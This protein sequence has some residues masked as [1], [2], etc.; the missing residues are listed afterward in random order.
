MIT[1]LQRLSASENIKREVTYKTIPANP[2]KYG[3]IQQSFAVDLHSYIPSELSIHVSVPNNPQDNPQAKM[4]TNND[5]H[6]KIFLY[7]GDEELL[8]EL[9]ELY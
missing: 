4:N 8:E 3:G 5:I 6:K 9:L 1:S 2:S 7:R